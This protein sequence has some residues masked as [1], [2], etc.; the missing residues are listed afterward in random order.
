MEQRLL[1]YTLQLANVAGPGVRFE[2]GHGFGGNVSRLPSELVT[3]ALQVVPN[4]ADQVFSA[5]TQRRQLD[6]E[7]S[8]AVVEIRPK[9]FPQR[10]A[11]LGHDA[12]P[13]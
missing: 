7:D 9:I 11:G 4:Q 6:R 2:N 5:V 12:L 3:K 8:E 13:R 10:S 1:E